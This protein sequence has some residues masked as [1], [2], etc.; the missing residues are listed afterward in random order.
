MTFFWDELTSWHMDNGN[1]GLINPK[2]LLNR[3]ATIEKS[4]IMTGGIP[5]LMNQLVG[6]L[7]HFFPYIGT[8]NLNWLSYFSEELKPPTSKPCFFYPGL[9]W[10]LE[11][12]AQSGRKCLEKYPLVRFQLEKNNSLCESRMDHMALDLSPSC[13]RWIRFHIVV[14]KS[15]TN[16]NV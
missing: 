12:G 10:H 3:E 1:P 15:E 2:R 7:E 5:P 11:D 4:Q 13:V 14:T 8:N 6:G 16:K 9:T